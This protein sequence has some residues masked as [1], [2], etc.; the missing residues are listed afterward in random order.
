MKKLTTTAVAIYRWTKSPMGRKDVAL[1]I[2]AADAIYTA[3]H[4]AGL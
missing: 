2:A 4:R 1:I 3:V